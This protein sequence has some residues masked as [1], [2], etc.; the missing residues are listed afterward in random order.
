MRTLAISLGNTSL[1][2]GVFAGATLKRSFRLPPSELAR[3]PRRIN[4]SIDRAVICSVVPLLTPDVLRLIHRTWKIEAHVLT[5]ASTIPIAIGY[6]RPRELGT[7]RL[8]AACGAYHQYPRK[9]VIIVDAGTATTV[10][11]LTKEG[12]LSGGAILPG[13]SLWAAALS[14]RTAQLP[15]IIPTRPKQALGRAPRE[16]IA[17][18]IFHG[19]VGAIRELVKR[20][21]EEAFGRS[22]PIVIGTGGNAPLLASAKLFTLVEPTLVLQGLRVVAEG[23]PS[24]TRRAVRSHRSD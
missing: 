19:H 12:R 20:I 5:A 10:T 11:A 18:G 9:N 4:G 13:L 6:R 24:L 23:L 17:S 22:P 3:L 16:A 8:A 2:V 1:F 21:G 14:D 15:K 7:D